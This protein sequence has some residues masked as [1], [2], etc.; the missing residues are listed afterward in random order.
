MERLSELFLCVS[1]SGSV[2]IYPLKGTSNPF[3][4]LYLIS[5]HS[6]FL[7][8]LFFSVIII[9]ITILNCGYYV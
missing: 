3:N 5:L 7:L 4:S 8:S 6:S 2:I 9:I 1:E